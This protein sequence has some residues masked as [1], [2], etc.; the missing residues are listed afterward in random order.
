MINKQSAVVWM[1]WT[2]FFFLFDKCTS[3]S[4]DVRVGKTR[5]S[6]QVFSVWQSSYLF[7]NRWGSTELHSEPNQAGGMLHRCATSDGGGGRVSEHSGHPGNL[8][9]AAL[10]PG[11]SGSL[12]LLRSWEKERKKKKEP[13]L[14]P[15]VKR[16]TVHILTRTNTS[17]GSHGIRLTLPA[18]KQNSPSA[19]SPKKIRLRSG[20]W[21]RWARRQ[22]ASV[23]SAKTLRNTGRT[24][25]S[26]AERIWQW[27]ILRTIFQLIKTI[28]NSSLFE[29]KK[30]MWLTQSQ[31]NT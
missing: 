21:T 20:V 11:I 29:A 17:L 4:I 15:P 5:L 18:Q 25:W 16:Q 24:S 12:H 7:S 9:S 28:T 14:T 19:K 30:Y 22:H 10:L 23:H 13:C 26:L 8:F 6:K 1:R 27:K 31:E 3:C 2:V